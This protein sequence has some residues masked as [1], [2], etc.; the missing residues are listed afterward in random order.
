MIHTVRSGNRVCV[1][2]PIK[3]GLII[4]LV[5]CAVLAL[6]FGR[7]DP[8]YTRWRNL[9]D[10]TSQDGVRRVLG[11]P[12]WTGKIGTIG[13]GDQQVTQ[14]QYKRGR[15]IYCVDFDYIGPGGAPVVYATDRYREEWEWSWPS[16]W[17]WGRARARA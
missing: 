7:R 13:A 12:S 14:W 9:K 15:V 6:M 10:G 1:P 3:R 5:V 2:S 16:W 8:F 17:P 4:A 11:E